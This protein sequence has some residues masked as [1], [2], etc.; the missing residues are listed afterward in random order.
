[1]FIVT[2]ILLEKLICP[3]LIVDKKLQLSSKYKVE[4]MIDKNKL[5]HTD[6]KMIYSKFNIKYYI[7]GEILAY[8]FSNNN[9]LRVAWLNSPS[10]NS[11][12]KDKDF[13]KIG[14]YTNNLYTACHFSD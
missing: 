4:Q 12:I 9:E 14:C 11:I 3:T 13:N 1:M 7:S 10:H 5:E 6:L 8:G 2:V